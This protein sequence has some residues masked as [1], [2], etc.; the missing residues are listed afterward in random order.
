MHEAV[1]PARQQLRDLQPWRLLAMLGG[2][3]LEGSVQGMALALEPQ[4]GALR[5]HG[6]LEFESTGR[7]RRDH[8]RN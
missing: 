6:Q 3:P 4:D 5:L 2:E 7:P 1:A 8:G